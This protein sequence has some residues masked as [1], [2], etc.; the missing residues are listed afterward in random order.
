MLGRT[1]IAFGFLAGVLL[2]PYIGGDPFLF[3]LLIA[4]GA[5]LPDVDHQGA[6]I[7]NLIP[8]TKV[9]PVFFKHRG[10]FHSIFPALILYAGF[11]V[12]G[13]ELL[14][15]PLVI[16]YAA[17][18]ISDSITIMGV[19]FLYPFSRFIL[20]GPLKTGTIQE[21]VVFVIVWVVVLVLW[22]V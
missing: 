18:L 11:W 16:G 3:Y 2:H 7:N 22:F 1:H 9:I 6:T 4:I 19:N 21:H 12:T 5:L 13:R 10:F 20:K 17:H 15:I 14:A 8:V